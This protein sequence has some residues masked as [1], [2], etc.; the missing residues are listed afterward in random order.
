MSRL[1][2]T[3]PSCGAKVAFESSI[4]ATA[5]CGYCRSLC[6]RDDQGV[7]DLGKVGQLLPDAS[8][9]QVG[10]KGRYGEERF[11]VLGRLQ[12]KYDQGVWNEWFLG[13]DGARE[14]WLGEAQGLYAVNFLVE[15]KSKLPDYDALS[16]G[17]EVALDTGQYEVR[18]KRAASYA[19]AE[20]QL[21][22]SAP[23]KTEFPSVDLAGEDSQ[24][25]TIDYSE[26]K[27]LL[28]AGRY[29]PFESFAF[30]N[31]RSFEGW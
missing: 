25:A 1:E 11:E 28:F 22:F 7:K 29:L 26:D 31:L 6:M 8:P 19:S 14:G 10:T 27:P 15:S 17:Q 5:V 16:I 4:S 18:D 13:F 20:G 9:I 12:L 23:I 24:F 21:P 30:E 3:C 2:F